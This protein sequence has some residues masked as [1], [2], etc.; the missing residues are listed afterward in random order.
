M[1]GTLGHLILVD[2]G[3]HTV[4][5]LQDK[6]IGN[7]SAGVV[8]KE[9]RFEAHKTGFRTCPLLMP[10]AGLGPCP[11]LLC[12]SISALQALSC[13]EEQMYLPCVW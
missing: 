13:K 2:T 7:V 6:Y 11:V 8:E 12:A 9:H 10:A 5:Y 3:P 1:L 4:S